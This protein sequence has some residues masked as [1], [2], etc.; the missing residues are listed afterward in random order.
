ML[1]LP[2]TFKI[3]GGLIYKD[4]GDIGKEDMAWEYIVFGR[5]SV[6]VSLRTRN[7]ETGRVGGA[8]LPSPQPIGMIFRKGAR[9]NA[10][11][12][13]IAGETLAGEG[14][15]ANPPSWKTN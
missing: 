3:L 10:T 5:N 1:P 4:Q 13:C 14:C 15:L 9:I 2:I 7:Q 11:S 6:T 8:R 12:F